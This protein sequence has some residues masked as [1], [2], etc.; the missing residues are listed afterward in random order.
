V[1]PSQ[2]LENIQ[3]RVPHRRKRSR[4]GLHLKKI[5]RSVTLPESEMNSLTAADELASNVASVEDEDTTSVSG[6]EKPKVK[7][8]RSECLMRA[9]MCRGRK[10]WSRGELTRA[11]SA[12]FGHNPE[13]DVPMSEP[14]VSD[15]EQ[16]VMKG[17]A[18]DN[19]RETLDEHSY[20]KL[21]DDIDDGTG[22]KEST[23]LQ[24][25]DD[26]QGPKGE[27]SGMVSG[28]LQGKVLVY[29]YSKIESVEMN[30]C[31]YCPIVRI[32]LSLAPP[33]G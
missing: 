27:Q 20:T 21:Q 19:G 4:R 15:E 12:A 28:Q 26:V 6:D 13:E 31:V 1:P 10:R 30:L 32:F 18:D 14:V 22:I 9:R 24:P 3:T 33:C 23:E 11:P 25:S 29:W 16:K 7:L 17:N 8:T 5:Y 2:K